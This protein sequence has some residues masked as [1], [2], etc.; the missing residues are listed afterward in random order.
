MTQESPFEKAVSRA[1][2]YLGA[3]EWRT[4]ALENFG[5][6]I[7]G[8]EA[9]NDNP[10]D[11]FEDAASDFIALQKVKF[12]LA[13]KLRWNE[14]LTRSEE[15]WIAKYLAGEIEELKPGK[16]RTGSRADELAIVMAVYHAAEAGGIKPTRNEATQPEESACDAVATAMKQLNRKPQSFRHIKAIWEKWGHLH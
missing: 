8:R 16:R 7:V 13:Q 14:C 12:G 15:A 1:L 9:L 3:H 4:K 11:L 2:E 6:G 10:D 5:Y